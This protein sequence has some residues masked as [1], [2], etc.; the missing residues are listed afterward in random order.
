MCTCK[1]LDN[2]YD[3]QFSEHQC[4][5]G[6]KTSDCDNR[7]AKSMQPDNFP[8][9]DVQGNPRKEKPLKGVENASIRSAHVEVSNSMRRIYSQVHHCRRSSCHPPTELISQVTAMNLTWV[10]AECATMYFSLDVATP[11]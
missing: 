7:T 4:E 8:V 1:K 9:K 3:Q 6:Q 11:R 10:L 2:G 5:S